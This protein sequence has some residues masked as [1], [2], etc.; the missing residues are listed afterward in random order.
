MPDESEALGLLALMLLQDS[1][2]AARTDA[3][4]YVALGDQ[5]RSLWDYAQVAEGLRAS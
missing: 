3:S 1:R 5:D 2:R 4:G